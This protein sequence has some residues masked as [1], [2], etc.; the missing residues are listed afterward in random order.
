MRANHYLTAEGY[1]PSQR[2]NFERERIAV[3]VQCAVEPR[4]MKFL[5][6]LIG[7]YQ[8]QRVISELIQDG[9]II[10]VLIGK[11]KQVGYKANFAKLTPNSFF[12]EE[13]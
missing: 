11:T 3:I 4:T 2:V 9:Y 6:R 12:T 1:T 7:A 13:R 10:R 5:A 8:A